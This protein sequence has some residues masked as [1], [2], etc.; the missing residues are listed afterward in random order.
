MK[1][2]PSLIFL[3]SH[4]LYGISNAREKERKVSE[5]QEAGPFEIL[6]AR[7][8]TCNHCGY[9]I[10]SSLSSFFHNQEQ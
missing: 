9:L 1:R 3:D 2:K 5:V 8:G 6:E 10:A 7:E 4:Y